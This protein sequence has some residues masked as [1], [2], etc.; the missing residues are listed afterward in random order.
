[1]AS[2]ID[3]ISQFNPYVQ[4]LPVDAMVK[5]GM[6]KQAQYDQGVQKIQSYIDSIAGLDIV[7][8]EHRQYLQSKLNELGGKLK[9]VAGGD[10][11]NYQLVNSVG[12]MAT[13]IVKDP[14]VQ[15]AISST[16]KVRKGQQELDA[17]KQAG[18]SSVQNE[19]FWSKT[20]NDWM[21]DGQMDSSFNGQYIQYSDVDKKL[22]EVAEKVHEYD[23]TIQVPYKKDNAGNVLYFKQDPKT[24][25]QIQTTQA[26]GKPIVDQALL[27]IT[28]K[29]K[30]AQKIYDNFKMSLTENDVQQLHIDSWYHYRGATKDMFKK[31]AL[32]TYELTKKQVSQGLVDMGIELSTNTQLTSTQKTALE[33]RMSNVKDMLNN[34]ELEKDLQTKLAE[35]ESGNLESMKYNLYADKY[36]KQLANAMSYESKQTAIKDNP[37]WKAEMDVKNL[38]FKY[39]N[40]AQEQRNW[41][42]SYEQKDRELALKSAENYIKTGG[43]GPVVESGGLRTDIKTP[44]VAGIQSDIN[45]IDDQMKKLKNTYANIIVPND[46]KNIKD[47]KERNAKIQSFYDG[48]ISKYTT[49]PSS[50]KDPD[51]KRFFEQY[52]AKEMLATQ[53]MNTL[54]QVWDKS[55]VYDEQL[56]KVLGAEAGITFS[57]GKTLYTGKELFEI[58]NDLKSFYRSSGGGG[59]YSTPT[60]VLNTGEILKKYKGTKYEPI[61]QAFV[62]NYN[63]Q[64][65]TPTENA[66]FTRQL[67]LTQK[68]Q[69][70]LTQIAKEKGDFQSSELAKLMPEYQSSIGTLNM[71]DKNIE[72]RVTGLLGNSAYLYDVYKSLDVDKKD[73]FNPDTV[74]K[75]RTS[76]EGKDLKYVIE[77]HF[78][79][80][81]ANLIIFNGTEKQTVPLTQE[82]FQ[83]HFPQYAKTN[84]MTSVKD[85]VLSTA[86]KTTNVGGVRDSATGA[87]NAFFTG[88]A[89]PFLVG[90][91]LENIV[92]A[93]VEGEP[94][95]NGSN[96][97]LFKL[98]IYVFKNGEWVTGLATG[99]E[100]MTL[101]QLEQVMQNVGTKTI[102][103]ITK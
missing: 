67:Q 59:M 21:S 14:T 23:N 56:D 101:P 40:A 70:T 10:F 32:S 5:V 99:N 34:G 90:T 13:Q 54:M 102:Q 45:M 37:Y 74:T 66:I 50:I 6:Q 44:T 71:E 27:E 87:V 55:K 49:D 36:L 78:D 94:S 3:A 68:H 25:Q 15:T 57:N 97:D 48:I 35:I 60:T 42:L 98:R 43:S 51:H 38:Q 65:L 77:K 19:A 89:F 12:G 80:S 53:K 84:P 31:D 20:V 86:S 103:D 1:M 62:K 47:E 73:M 4:Q 26:D 100:Y 88:N 7:K 24:G 28:T 11:S 2:F 29:G 33:A 18:K 30:S 8:P 69:G 83:S 63:G 22:R 46:I 16:Q 92:R 61:A 9:T 91:G 58:G 85:A 52:R 95:N 79:G 82:Q 96:S 76:K 81:G 41:K 17:A 72:T 75:W 39:D 64:P 93:D